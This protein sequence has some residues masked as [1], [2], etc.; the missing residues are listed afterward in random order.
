[1]ARRKVAGGM[2]AHHHVAQTHGYTTAG[3][4]QYTSYGFVG[5]VEEWLEVGS[6]SPLVWI[7]NSQG[8]GFP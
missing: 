7:H 2:H 1:M 5:G 8:R 3:L 4:G 6:W